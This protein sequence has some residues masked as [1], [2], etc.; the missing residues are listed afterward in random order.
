MT[1]TTSSRRNPRALLRFNGAF[2]SPLQISL[3]RNR[4]RKSPRSVKCTGNPQLVKTR[5]E[6]DPGAADSDCV[7]TRGES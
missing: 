4:R 3:A 2:A 5:T 7:P 1:T 6:P